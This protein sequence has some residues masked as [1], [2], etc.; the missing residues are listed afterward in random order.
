MAENIFL[1]TLASKNYCP[2]MANDPILE[3]SNKIL[4][5]FNGTS[6]AA[7]RKMAEIFHSAL[8]LSID[9]LYWHL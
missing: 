3:S 2:V 9:I 5:K 6:S 7:E 8:N 4:T 1:T